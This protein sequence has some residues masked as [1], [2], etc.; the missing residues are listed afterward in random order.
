[1]FY[2]FQISAIRISEEQMDWYY[3]CSEKGENI[4]TLP[5]K[6][7]KKK[8]ISH[9]GNLNLVQDTLHLLQKKKKKKVLLK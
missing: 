7:K 6:K 1:M 2:D 4:Y 8:K 3:I 5:L 9:K